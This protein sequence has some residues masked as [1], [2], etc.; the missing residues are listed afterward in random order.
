MR[1][2]ASAYNFSIFKARTLE[3]FIGLRVRRRCSSDRLIG[4]N[5]LYVWGNIHLPKNISSQT[6]I[7]RVEDGFLRSVGLGITLNR[8]ISWV[9]DTR[10]MYYDASC[11][12]DIEY[13]L[14]TCTF[15][16][17]I[18]QR[19]ELLR[20]KIIL[21]GITKYNVDINRIWHRP[22]WTHI[23]LV[24]GQV[25]R[26]ASLEFGAKNIK[27]NLSLLQAVRRVNPYS[28]IVYKPHPD[29]VSGIRKG[30][31]ASA[32][33]YANEIVTDSDIASL[34]EGVDE[35]HVMTSLT[36]FEAL[37]RGKKVVCYGSPFYSGW[38]L[39]VDYLKNVR[40]VRKLSLDQLVAGALILYPRYINPENGAH[41]EPEDA[42]DWLLMQRSLPKSK[43]DPIKTIAMRIASRFIHV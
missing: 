14:S 27:T 26:D 39:T 35:V 15:S 32:L 19:A 1:E 37:L 13:I 29:V 30:N 38:G 8:P 3:R 5:T 40:R 22:S 6:K 18:L 2:L 41:W 20:T 24:P 36:G 23:I 9:F 10:G 43:I 17:Q 11:V 34:I 7:I 31:D 21:S 25:E 16:Y 4:L 12:S 28:Y 42:I 33:C